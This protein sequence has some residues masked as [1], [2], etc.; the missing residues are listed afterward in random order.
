MD[1]CSILDY[2]NSAL[3][4]RSQCLAHSD[5][6]LNPPASASQVEC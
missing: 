6:R 1:K 3:E 4:I 2:I 5:L